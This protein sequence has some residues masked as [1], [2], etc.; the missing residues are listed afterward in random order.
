[1]FSTRVAK[2]PMV[3][4]LRKNFQTFLGISRTSMESFWMAISVGVLTE[5]TKRLPF[6]LSMRPSWSSRAGFLS[7]WVREELS[8]TSLNTSVHRCEIH[9][10]LA[11]GNASCIAWICILLQNSIHSTLQ[12]CTQKKQH[13][14]L[15]SFWRPGDIGFII[16]SVLNINFDHCNHYGI[17]SCR[18]Q[19]WLPTCRQPSLKPQRPT[20]TRVNCWGPWR[21]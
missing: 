21:P 13:M 7:F 5:L 11:Q 1:M 12:L 20:R 9:K 2:G 18:G 8:G 4:Q 17:P 14:A 10:R 16:P 6:D 3:R 15:I 19:W